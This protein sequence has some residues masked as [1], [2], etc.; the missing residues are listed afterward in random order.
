MAVSVTL[1]GA[2]KIGHKHGQILSVLDGVDEIYVVDVD[3]EAAAETAATIGGTH[4]SRDRAFEQSTA[5]Y[6]CTPDDTHAQLTAAAMDHGLDTFVEK[7]LAVDPAAAVALRDRAAQAETVHMVGHI[8]RFDP[9]YTQAATAV[10]AGDIGQL[11]HAST[12]RLVGRDRVRRTGGGYRPPSRLGVHDFDVL[13]WIVGERLVSVSAAGVDGALGAEGYETE[14]VVSVM[15]RFESGAT[16][17][18]VFGF[19]LPST[20][21][22]SLVEMQ[23]LGTDGVVTVDAG[24]TPTTKWS[25][26]GAQGLDTHLWPT[27]QGVPGG[28]LHNESAAFIR[29]ITKDEHTPVPFSAGARAAQVAT[30]V[31]RSLNTGGEVRVGQDL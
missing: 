16:A 18:L 15:G 14:E 5:A 7:P 30:A 29:A 9:R 22:G 24:T 20:A 13:E 6:V 19:C 8:L 25:A 26:N 10:E 12:T 11:T 21:P 2:G 17:T 1:L 28:A 23:L 3:D 27:I 31:T 4:V